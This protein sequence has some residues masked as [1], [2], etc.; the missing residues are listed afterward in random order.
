MHFWD[1]L[2]IVQTSLLNISFVKI[3]WMT[4]AALTIILTKLEAEIYEP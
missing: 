3:P 4:Q 2:E 1:I